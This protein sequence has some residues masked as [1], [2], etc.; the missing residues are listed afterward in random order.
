MLSKHENAS[1]YQSK[2]DNL[3]HDYKDNFTNVE[4]ISIG[5]S[6][7]FYKATF[8]KCNI[9]TIL[10]P[11]TISQQFSLNE[12][13]NEINQY[14]NIKF[15]DSILKIFGLTKPDPNTYMVIFEY[16][17]GGTLR[18]YLEQNFK[19]M[20][21]RNKL[22]LAKQ[23]ANAIKHLHANNIIHGHLNSENI[24]INK[25][26]VKISG[27]PSKIFMNQNQYQNLLS[28]VQYFDPKY[29]QNLKSYNL[30]QS[31]DVYSVGVLLWE[32]SSGTI[33]FESESPF[34]YNCLLDIIRGKRE[35]EI[36]GTPR[37]YSLIYK[38]CWN[39][40]ASKRPNIQQVVAR[41]NKIN[42]LM[43]EEFDLI[44]IQQNTDQEDQQS[45]NKTDERHLVI[46][47][48]LQFFISQFNSTIKTSQIT[49]NLTNYF[50]TNQ[51]D[52]FLIFNQLAY[53][54]YNFSMIGYFYE[55]GIGTDVDYHKAFWMYKL[56][57][58]SDINIDD[59]SLVGNFN[60]NN[61][62]IGKI[63]LGLLY[64][65]GKGVDMDKCMTFKL[66]LESAEM[67]SS[68]GQYYV[69]SCYL[70]SDYGIERDE[71]KSFEWFLKSAVNGNS[72]AQNQV[73]KCYINGTGTDI[74]K[75]KAFESYSKSAEYG[76]ID[77][78]FELANCYING[79]GT[80]IYMTKAFELYF[81]SAES[82]N[83]AAQFE[84]A[85]CYKNGTGVEIDKDKAFELYLKSAENGNA[86]AIY[87][88]ANCYAVGTGTDKNYERAF[89][90]YMKSAEL[91]YSKGIKAVAICY[92]FG[93]GIIK[94]NLK[95][96]EWYLKYR[97]KK[98]DNV[99]KAIYLI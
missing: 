5:E 31:S 46:G 92:E 18:Q 43:I 53:Q 4:P 60:L 87:E 96:A 63:S 37:E 74:D 14:Q 81:K 9:T 2:E 56:S 70:C 61:Y 54:D 27:F 65:T 16:A 41:L 36:T 32:I 45:S 40:D 95:A 67:G 97:K 98:A 20:G 8:K 78:I 7:W 1:N 44:H 39:Y 57:S 88:L 62:I 38:D 26:N 86:A 15:H 72:E 21:W 47:K 93:L 84:L 50:E 17:D 94:D 82:G 90:W 59:S 33:P 85:N 49:K 89:D 48:L 30:N 6:E 73:A 42:E 55:H 34:G 58:E 19:L 77:A 23:I 99:S 80:N 76:N 91:D 51:I 22:R 12:L 25:G 66:F 29:L 35:T 3:I 10:K 79:I 83:S 28:F 13:I 52:P 24:L 75:E 69:G 11:I 68:I 71:K 64:S